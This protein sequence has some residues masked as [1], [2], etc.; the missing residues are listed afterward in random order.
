MALLHVHFESYLVVVSCRCSKPV[1]VV[2]I[3][4]I[5]TLNAH[6]DGLILCDNDK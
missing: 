5:V 3:V 2:C 1:S 4:V 6:N